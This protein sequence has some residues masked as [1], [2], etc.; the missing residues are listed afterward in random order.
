MGVMAPG[1]E[2]ETAFMPGD[3]HF[4]EQLLCMDE[5]IGTREGGPPWLLSL[6][7]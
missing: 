1:T 2:A 3:L 4:S 6:K 5:I 7:M